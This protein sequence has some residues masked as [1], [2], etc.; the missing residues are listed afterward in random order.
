MLSAST[1]ERA[2]ADVHV[3]IDNTLEAVIARHGWDIRSIHRY[4][5]GPDPIPYTGD[6][7]EDELKERNVFFSAI[8]AEELLERLT[9]EAALKRFHEIR[10]DLILSNIRLVMSI[11]RG[12]A[13]GDDLD[14]VDIFQT[15][16]MGLMT[17]MDRFDAYRG[18]R[19]STFATH[20]IRQAIGRS[21]ANEGAK[22]TSSSSC[23]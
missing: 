3:I 21:R 18:L 8:M 20:W 13:R 12:R 9:R 5:L 4:A 11:A 2:K 16:V 6:A 10:N 19:F 7:A 22:R 17:A 15:G 23:A 1:W 14:L